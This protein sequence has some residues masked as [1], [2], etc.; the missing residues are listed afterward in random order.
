MVNFKNGG[1]AVVAALMLTA[2]SQ[3]AGKTGAPPVAE[4]SQQRPTLEVEPPATFL[5]SC[6]YSTGWPG[7]NLVSLGQLVDLIKRNTS[8]SVS[9]DKDNGGGYILR[10]ATVDQVAQKT[11]NF[12]IL[13]E[14]EPPG[15]NRDPEITT[16]GCGPN[17]VWLSRDVL[18]GQELGPVSAFS[19]LEDAQVLDH[20][21]VSRF[22]GASPTANS[23]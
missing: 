17:T 23:P 8:T 4:S 10:I 16:T 18:D 3:P 15:A 1:A 5:A 7:N 9:W 11:H 20:E 12:A 13:L 14:N 21:Q 2:C 6:F 19:A 22:A